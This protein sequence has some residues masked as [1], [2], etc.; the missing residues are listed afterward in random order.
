ML[1]PTQLSMISPRDL[2]SFSVFR[3]F[4][5]ETSGTKFRRTLMAHPRVGHFST[6]GLPASWHAQ[7]HH[8]TSGCSESALG[9]LAWCSAD[10]HRVSLLCSAG[11]HTVGRSKAWKPHSDLWNSPKVLHCTTHVSQ[12][13]ST[14]W[15]SSID[16]LLLWVSWLPPK[17]TGS[18]HASPQFPSRKL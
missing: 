7:F 9:S 5:L 10:C 16:F 11:L 6:L 18:M 8:A 3:D 4:T 15:I 12:F 1:L 13:L 2:V 14:L 17:N